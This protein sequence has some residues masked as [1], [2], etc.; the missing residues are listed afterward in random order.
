[1]IHSRADRSAEALR[2]PKAAGDMDPMFFS[3]LRGW[4]DMVS[5]RP[6]LAR[7]TCPPS[8]EALGLIVSSSGLGRC[9]PHAAPRKQPALKPLAPILVETGSEASG[10]YSRLQ[11]AVDFIVQSRLAW[12]PGPYAL[13]LIESISAHKDSYHAH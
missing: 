5:F 10:A 6:G 4:C 13:L 9:M 8:A 12:P 7:A 11:H 3:L 2:H 1:M